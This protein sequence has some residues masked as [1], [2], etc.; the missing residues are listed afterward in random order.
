MKWLVY[1]SFIIV[2]L[3][4]TAFGIGPVVFA[5]GPTDERILTL[6]VVLVIYAMLAGC[7][8]LYRKR[9]IMK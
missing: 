8:I 4:V 5:D 6:I 2:F 9:N 3:A 1:T 7:L